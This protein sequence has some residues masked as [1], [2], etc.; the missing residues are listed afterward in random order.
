[1]YDTN[2]NAQTYTG[3]ENIVIDDTNEIS[4][5]LP[6]KVNDEVIFNPRAYNALFQLYSGPDNL[7][8]NQNQ[9]T[10]HNRSYHSSLKPNQQHFMEM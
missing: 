7:T 3:S 5:H 10:L 4:L 2:L 1:M 6:I 8:I 9:Y